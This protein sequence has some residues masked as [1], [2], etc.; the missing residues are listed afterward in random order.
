MRSLFE[1]LNGLQGILDVL[2]IHILKLDG[3]NHLQQSVH[4]ASRLNDLLNVQMTVLGQEFLLSFLVGQ[5]NLRQVTNHTVEDVVIGLMLDLIDTI[6]SQTGLRLL[7]SITVVVVIRTLSS[8][9]TSSSLL[10]NG[11]YILLVCS[12]HASHDDIQHWRHASGSDW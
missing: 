5:S 2:L 9:D 10:Q 8:L 6:L 3:T 1:L 7:N 4:A 12:Q 11:L